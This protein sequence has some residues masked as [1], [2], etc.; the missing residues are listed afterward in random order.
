MPAASSR[1]PPAILVP[2]LLILV[3]L[4]SFITAFLLP[5]L[6]FSSSFFPPSSILQSRR[7]SSTASPSFSPLHPPFLP[8]RAAADDNKDQPPTPKGF[9]KKQPKKAAPSSSLPSSSPPSSSSEA[10]EPDNPLA[11]SQA[12]LDELDRLSARQKRSYWEIQ[13]EMEREMDMREIAEYKETQ[14]L[15][16][17]GIVGNLPEQISNRMLK[18]LLPFT[19]VPVLGGIA[20]FGFFLYLAKNTEIDVPPAFV[21]FSTQVPF[22]AALAGISYSIMSTSWDPEVEGSFWGFTEF[23]ANVLNLLDSLQKTRR[24][25]SAKKKLEKYSGTQ[26]PNRAKRRELD[27]LTK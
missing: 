14:R 18:R 4:P 2:I 10:N 16:D 6:P 1:G 5:T 19:F 11:A 13:A 15:L 12:S 17:E 24:E 27:R 22:L 23:K 26:A 7:H 21:A 25:E 20:L 8:F 9:A 3:L